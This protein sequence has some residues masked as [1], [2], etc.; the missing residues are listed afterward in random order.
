MLG[1]RAK[2]QDK[3]LLRKIPSF[4][5]N[6]LIRKVTGVHIKDMGCTLRAMR[7]ELAEALPLYG[8]LWVVGGGLAYSV[9]VGFLSA[10]QMRYG[11]FVWHL[12]V[13][14]GSACHWVAIFRYA[15]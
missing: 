6:W 1:L 15:A 14:V 5:G 4:M 7:R 10:R 11:H 3:L 2:R 8:V 12:F 9:G 13:L